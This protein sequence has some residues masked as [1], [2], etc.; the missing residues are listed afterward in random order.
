M[1]E[2]I[3]MLVVDADTE[4]AKGLSEYA[5]TR[6]EFLDTDYATNG[7]DGYRQIMMV[8]PDV[9]IMDFLLSGLDGIGLLRQLKAKTEEQRPKVII[10]S[11]TM[12]QTMLNAASE[13]GA[14]YFMVKPQPFSEVC[15]TVT[16]LIKK[17]DGRVKDEEPK[18]KLDIRLTKF[19]HYL[20]VPAHLKG[21]QYIRAALRLSIEDIGRVTPITRRLYPELAVMY[22]T[23]AECIER[24]IRHAIKVSWERGN[25]KVLGDIFGYS[26]ESSYGGYPTNS[27]YIAMVTDEIRIKMRYDSEW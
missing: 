19:L 16:D 9:I 3:T 8:K 26:S 15:N 12:L 6:D 13:Y 21:Y 25:K 2:G 14:D 22:N 17:E 20:G 27:E 1:S 18:E 24:S 7:L 4:Y 10:N 5:K 23:T 11:G